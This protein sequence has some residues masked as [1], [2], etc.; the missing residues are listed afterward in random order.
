MAKAKSP[1]PPR[2]TDPA[3]HLYSSLRE[4]IVEHVFVGEA[5]RA[6]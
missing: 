6:L 5:L 4:K 1:K 3:H 2:N